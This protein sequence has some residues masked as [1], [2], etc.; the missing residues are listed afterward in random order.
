MSFLEELKNSNHTEKTEKTP[1]ELWESCFKYFKH[2]VSIIQKD[3]S[4]FAAEFNFIF[5]NLKRESLIT[6]PYE[7]SRTQN[8][9]ELKLEVKLTTQLQQSV[10]V[11]NKN[12]RAAEILK[13]KLA[14]DSI[15]SVV[16]NDKDNNCFLELNSNI[17]SIF[18]ITLK[19]NRDF[20]LEYK[21]ICTSTS[22]SMHLAIDNINEEYMD[23]LAKYILGQNPSLYTETISNKKITKIRNQIE[24]NK[25]LQAQKDAVLKVEI[26]Q[27]KK[28]EQLR[29]A[30]SFKEKSKNYLSAKSKE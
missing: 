14:K 13:T 23:K 1:R 29:K 30:N 4:S 10:R 19:N 12:Q 26:E 17:Q 11:E 7:I 3:N 6:G 16:K 25:R 28:E 5:L 21:N 27:Q 2:F 20:Y 18:R 22:K 9:E 8:D 24:L 15:Y